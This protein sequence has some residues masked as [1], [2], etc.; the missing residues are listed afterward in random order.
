MTRRFERGRRLAM[1]PR[2]AL[3]RVHRYLGLT[4]ALWVVLQGLTG[5][6]LVGADQIN[7]WSRPELFHRTDGDVGPAAA[8]DAARHRAG[9]GRVVTL[10]LPAAQHG[11]YMAVV[12]R[13]PAGPAAPQRWVYVDPGTGR[14]NGMRD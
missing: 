9:S 10:H 2:R 5:M 13:P 4:L 12:S 11:V 1:R 3:V 14:V 8:V 7:A 6:V